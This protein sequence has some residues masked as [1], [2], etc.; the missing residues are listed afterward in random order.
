MK[1]VHIL[2][3]LIFIFIFEHWNVEG[4][5][6]MRLRCCKSFAVYCSRCAVGTRCHY[7]DYLIA[8]HLGNWTPDSIPF[9]E[10]L[11]GMFD[12]IKEKLESDSHYFSQQTILGFFRDTLDGLTND[13]KRCKE[14]QETIDVTEHIKQASS[15]LSAIEG[16][17]NG[18][19]VTAAIEEITKTLELLE[20]IPYKLSVPRK[21]NCENTGNIGNSKW[22]PIIDCREE[23]N[24]AVTPPGI[25]KPNYFL[26]HNIYHL[27]CY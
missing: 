13:C 18:V 2:S 11:I 23:M 22:Q 7:C 3:L 14:H 8:Y 10:P 6:G 25:L 21:V 12:D 1:G 9:K 17:N 19:F 27:R 5:K 20:K 16:S 15:R 4:K 26:L 24:L